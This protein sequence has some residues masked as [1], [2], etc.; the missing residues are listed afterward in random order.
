MTLIL[1]IADLFNIKV[2]SGCCKFT[3]HWV[4][5]FSAELSGP[6]QPEGRKIVLNFCPDCY[7]DFCELMLKEKP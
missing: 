2:C 6:H 5:C 7:P 4:C 1:F 3:L